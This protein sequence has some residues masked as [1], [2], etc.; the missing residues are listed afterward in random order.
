MA[1]VPMKK[2]RFST[3]YLIK[4]TGKSIKSSC[5]FTNYRDR[6]YLPLKE[7]GALKIFR[8]ACNHALERRQV[9]EEVPL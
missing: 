8:N 7:G 5:I 1:V 4:A 6:L 9:V 3:A 2:V